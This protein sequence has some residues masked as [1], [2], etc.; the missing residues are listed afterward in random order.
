MQKEKK[1][2]LIGTVL[3]L[4]G[5][6]SLLNNFGLIFIRD[7]AIVSLLF[8]SLGTF[9]FT[10][11]AREQRVGY[12]ILASIST[13]I[14]LVILWDSIL[15]FDSQFIGVI[16]L[17]GVSALFAYGFF[18]NNENW[19]FV[20]P[21]GIFF[22]LGCVV[23]FEMT[24]FIHSDVLGSVFFLGLGLTF[25]FLYLIKNEKNGLD[26]AEAPAI[27]LIAFSG[28]LLVV[29]S[30]SFLATIFFPITLILLGA[31]LI[32]VASKDKRVAKHVKKA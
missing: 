6:L 12:L 11:F 5:I 13:F 1:S 9:L 31:Y 19:G 29:S 22:T 25:G 3:I 23:L 7:E 17:W 26:W 20:I 30:N 32:L 14:G 4:L 28:F 24:P 2:L 8:L 21:A 16:F 10:R 15:G 18:R 27:C